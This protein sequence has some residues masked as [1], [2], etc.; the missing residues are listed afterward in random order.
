[1]A[2]DYTR[3][4][5]LPDFTADEKAIVDAQFFHLMYRYGVGRECVDLNEQVAEGW[6]LMPASLRLRKIMN[7]L[8]VDEPSF[9]NIGEGP[10][11]ISQKLYEGYLARLLYVHGITAVRVEILNDEPKLSAQ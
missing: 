8:R 3:G 1:M 9:P 6:S 5:G 7:R 11:P 2:S 10:V 4:K